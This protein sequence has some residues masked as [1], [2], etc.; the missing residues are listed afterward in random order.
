LHIYTIHFDEYMSFSY[1]FIILGMEIP[2]V[3]CI[4]VPK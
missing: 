4:F 3:L 1:K 2:I